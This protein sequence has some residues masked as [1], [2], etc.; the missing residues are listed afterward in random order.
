MP[1]RAHTYTVEVGHNWVSITG[2]LSEAA[3]DVRSAI[4]QLEARFTELAAAQHMA[5]FPIYIMY[6]YCDDDSLARLRTSFTDCRVPIL[7][8]RMGPSR[9]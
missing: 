7:F 5:P 9:H 3:P 1:K 6:E 2:D 4:S 8:T